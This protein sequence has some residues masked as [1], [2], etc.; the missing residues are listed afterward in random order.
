MVTAVVVLVEVPE[1]VDRIVSGLRGVNRELPILAATQNLSLFERLNEYAL[2][3]VFIKND[4][5][6]RLLA[7]ALLEKLSFSREAI[8]QVLSF[9]AEA[10]AARAA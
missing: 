2:T 10:E 5:T 6:P 7:K 4:E 1:I 3:A 8:D 9:Q